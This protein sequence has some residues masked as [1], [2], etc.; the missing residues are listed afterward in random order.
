MK[1]TVFN[2]MVLYTQMHLLLSYQ[3]LISVIIVS[4]RGIS[5]LTSITMEYLV[6][7]RAISASLDVLSWE[8][9]PLMEALLTA[10]REQS[11]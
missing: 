2:I 4:I 6:H 8:I 5:P 10:M 3:T 1:Q 7:L 9:Q 11:L